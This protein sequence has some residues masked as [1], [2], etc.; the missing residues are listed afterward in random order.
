MNQQ[1]QSKTTGLKVVPGTMRVHAVAPINRTRI[2]V[3]DT[4]CNCQN[5]INSTVNN[6]CEGWR[7]FDLKAPN[8]EQELEDESSIVREQHIVVPKVGTFVSAI[9]D[10]KWYVGLV[11]AIE[12]DE[13]EINFMQQAGKVTNR[14]K[15]PS[16][17]DE[18][19]LPVRNILSVVP[20][21][22]PS[23]K[24]KRLYEVNNSV[25][26]LIDDLFKKRTCTHT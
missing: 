1:I 4:S 9:Y 10:T 22:Q 2:A 18:I 19:W 24:T 16:I 7:Y 8:K 12:D 20:D 14:F 11:T 5:C 6:K 21:P 23:G 17:K 13:V 3:R 25:V 15:W 26:E